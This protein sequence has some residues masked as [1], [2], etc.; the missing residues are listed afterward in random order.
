MNSSVFYPLS[1]INSIDRPM[2]VKGEGIYLFD[3]RGKRYLDANSGLWNMPLGYSN[4]ALQQALTSQAMHL[5]YTN[6]I[7]FTSAPAE[8]YACDLLGVLGDAFSKVMYTCTGSECIECATKLARKYHFLKGNPRVNRILAFDM[9]YHGTTYAAMTASGMDRTEVTEYAPLNEQITLLKTPFFPAAEP[10]DTQKQYYL[11][12]LYAQFQA[13]DVA[14]V[15]LEPVLASGGVIALPD[16]YLNAL[17]RMITEEHALLIADEVAT[18]FG[19]AGEFF[20]S[21]CLPLKPHILCLSKAIDNGMVPMGAVLIDSTVECCYSQA[22]EYLN[23]FSTQCANP[24]ACAVASET[25]REL[26]TSNRLSQVFETG[27]VLSKALNDSL[28]GLHCVR[29][30]RNIG[31]MFAIDLVSEG[32]PMSMDLL[33]KIQVRLMQRGLISYLFFT[34]M[35]TSG[36]MLMPPYLIGAGDIDFI[37]DTFKK[38]LMYCI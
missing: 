33:Y 28:N 26:T 24:I 6:M 11:D 35:L 29:E 12:N 27:K 34:P 13:H 25:L 17:C 32:S 37:V 23:H 7:N 3:S 1:P 22:N 5:P 15:L 9:S 19:R 38:T 30:L 36:L 8:T 21:S 10:T 20:A 2:F 31:M 16:W 4:Q 14:A 18:G